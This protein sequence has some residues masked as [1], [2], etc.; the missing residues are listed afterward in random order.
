MPRRWSPNLRSF[1]CVARRSALLAVLL[2]GPAA[3]ER[4]I[5]EPLA[6][7]PLDP[8]A[9]ATAP[10]R[11]PPKRPLATSRCLTPTPVTP[12][13]TSMPGPDGRCPRDPEATP[14]RLRTG[15]VTFVTG[16]GDGA[17]GKPFTV[18]VE[19]A[20]DDKVRQRGLMFRKQMEGDHGMIFAFP[21]R[22]EHSFWMHNTCIPL[23]MIFVD[24]DGFIVGIEENTPTIS[25]DTFSPGC[26]SKYV[27][28]VN[29]GVAR[30]HG[31]KA[32]QWVKMDL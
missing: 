25:D 17:A 14:P 23:D 19:I 2:V 31:V 15:K 26:P 7:R 12:K 8:S 13:R 29:A 20:A 24:E 16:E 30:A 4:R 5:E 10:G 27:I 11:A 32:G 28:E 18:D 1:G 6:A 21:E 9:L 22:E 3:C